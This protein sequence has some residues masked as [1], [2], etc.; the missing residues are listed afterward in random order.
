[1]FNAPASEA[2]VKVERTVFVITANGV[3]DGEVRY[4]RADG[5]WTRAWAEAEVLETTDARD[6]RLAWGRRREHEVCGCYAIDV[7][8]DASGAQHLSAREQLRAMG[9]ADVRGR[10]GYGA[11]S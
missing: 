3:D 1:M 10:L 7:G 6:E 5:G 4:L 11:A 2:S 9:P 8:V